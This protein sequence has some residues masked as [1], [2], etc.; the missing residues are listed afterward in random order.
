MAC[1]AYAITQGSSESVDVVLRLA[2]VAIE[3]EYVDRSRAKRGPD[4]P[5][6]PTTPMEVRLRHAAL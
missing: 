5:E 1:R 4:N 3:G 2:T 6:Q